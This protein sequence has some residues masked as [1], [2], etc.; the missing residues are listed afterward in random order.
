MASV[1]WKEDTYLKCEISISNP[2]GILVTFIITDD[3]GNEYEITAPRFSFN[4]IISSSAQVTQS[5]GKIS[6]VGQTPI[7]WNGDKLCQIGQYQIVWSSNKIMRIGRT[8]I[9]WNGD[10][11]CQIGQTQIVWYGN[12]ISRIGRASVLPNGSISGN[13][14]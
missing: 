10:R 8:P 13:V 4:P 9:T 14:K 3:S 6:R 11:I 7:C 12:S 2:S 5:L 1:K